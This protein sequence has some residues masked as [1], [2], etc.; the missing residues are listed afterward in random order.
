MIA[1]SIFIKV[2]EAHRVNASKGYEVVLAY[3]E[4]NKAFGIKPMVE[5]VLKDEYDALKKKYDDM[6]KSLQDGQ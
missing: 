6:I 2:S 5:Y 1:K 4:R 3:S